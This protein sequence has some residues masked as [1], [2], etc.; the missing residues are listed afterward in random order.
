MAYPKKKPKGKILPIPA[1]HK[2]RYGASGSLGLIGGAGKGIVQIGKKVFKKVA[3]KV[4]L[5]KMSNRK[6]KKKNYGR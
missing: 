5:N 1:S 3:K 6:K 4:A 2:K